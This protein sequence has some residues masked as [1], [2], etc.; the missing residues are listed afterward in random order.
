MPGHLHGGYDKYC[1]IPNNN[2]PVTNYL[3]SRVLT[4]PMYPELKL[5]E[6][7]KISLKINNII[8]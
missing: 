8:F 6:A 1:K 2:L 5:Q 7:K 4:L 3:A